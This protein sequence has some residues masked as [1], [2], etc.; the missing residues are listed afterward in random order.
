MEAYAN[1]FADM[2]PKPT[3]AHTIERRDNNGPYSPDNC[4]WATRTEQANNRRSSRTLTHG[5]VT[6]TIATW[7]KIL[8]VNEFA[9]Y[10]RA[11][12]GWPV[13]RILSERIQPGRRKKCLP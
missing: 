1:F 7:A 5:G 2:G 13:E 3:P 12:A 10:R 8:R 11:D 4:Y 9:L 6:H